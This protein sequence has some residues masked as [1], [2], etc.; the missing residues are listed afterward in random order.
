MSETSEIYKELCTTYRAI[1]DI[2]MKLLGFLPLATGAGAFALLA[3]NGP[4]SDET[5]KYFLP[6]GIFGLLI[7]LGLYIYELYGIKKCTFLILTDKGLEGSLGVPGQF[8]TRPKAILGKLDEVL[9][10]CVIYPAVLAAWIYLSLVFRANR[11]LAAGAAIA[12]L[13]M[14]VVVWLILKW[15]L[16]NRAGEE[17]QK[18][19]EEVHDKTP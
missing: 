2:R 8:H 11:W 15:W 17:H 5:K 13:L 19:F 18:L 6:V 7:T 16:E 3:K 14:G 12:V 4:L 10:G 1:D 9:A